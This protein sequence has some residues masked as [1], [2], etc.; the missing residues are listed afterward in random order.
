MYT[1]QDIR[2]RPIYRDGWQQPSHAAALEQAKIRDANDQALLGRVEEAEEVEKQERAK[3]IILKQELDQKKRELERAR[4][5][6]E[7]QAT[8]PEVTALLAVVVGLMISAAKPST[9]R[10]YR[11]V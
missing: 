9:M 5:A 6:L 11:D 4:L 7:E 2:Q 10:R 3:R 8:A 1:N